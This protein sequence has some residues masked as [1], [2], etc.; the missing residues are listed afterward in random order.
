MLYPLSYRG[1][2][3]LR[4][5]ILRSKAGYFRAKSMIRFSLGRLFASPTLQCW[6]WRLKRS[7]LLLTAARPTFLDPHHAYSAFKKFIPSFWRRCPA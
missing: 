5:R 4:L 1:I 6:A 3:N 2:F 7:A